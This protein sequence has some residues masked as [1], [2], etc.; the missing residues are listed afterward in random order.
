MAPTG[1]PASPR[2]RRRHTQ[3]LA[4][5]ACDPGAE[6]AAWEEEK[7]SLAKMAGGI[8]AAQKLLG[9]AATSGNLADVKRALRGGADVNAAAYAVPGWAGLY[10]AAAVCVRHEQGALLRW[11]VAVGGADPDKG[12]DASDDWA[13]LY[14]AANL[15]DAPLV[16]L[17]LALGANPN[18]PDK[19][20]WAPVTVAAFCGHARVVAAL[21]EG[22]P[23]GSLDVRAINKV[24]MTALDYCCEG[25][26]AAAV[27]VLLGLGAGAN[28]LNR[29]HNTPCMK[30][31]AAG[32]AELV[33]VLAAFA[34]AGPAAAEH[35]GKLNVNVV[36]K[37]GRTALDYAMRGGHAA[38]ATALRRLGA[39]TKAQL[40]R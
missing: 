6:R 9:R 16:R 20:M 1:T 13:P 2:R 14:L 30:A 39:R 35:N 7:K 17:L 34:G 29:E 25:G 8:H 22:G 3:A 28:R 36:D 12:S 27:R 33:K 31:A 24:G 10:T 37:K 21:A 26:H 19:A 18:K 32:H 4:A 23:R 38:A 5:A 11:L 40:A 15:D